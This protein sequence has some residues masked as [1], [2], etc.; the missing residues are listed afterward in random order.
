VIRAVAFAILAALPGSGLGAA[1]GGVRVAEASAVVSGSSGPGLRSG[2]ADAAEAEVKRNV[3]SGLPPRPDSSSAQSEA[4]DETLPHGA[5][6]PAED[7]SATG[8][9][10]SPPAEDLLGELAAAIARATTQGALR[11]AP[12]KPGAEPPEGGGP[13]PSAANIRLRLPGEEAWLPEGETRAGDC[14]PEDAFNVA[15]WGAGDADPAEAI[16]ALRS[17][18]AADI[19]VIDEARALALARLY[20]SLGFG[21]E[22]RAVL[23]SLVPRDPSAQLLS[24]I[25]RVVDGEPGPSALF[26]GLADCP[27]RAQLWFA[28]AT[29]R[30]GAP[31]AVEFAVSELPLA[32]RRQV[33]PRLIESYARA[34]DMATA[35][36][37]RA[38]VERAA[39]P[40]G[41]GFELAAARLDIG[42]DNEAGLDPIRSL[43]APTSPSSDDALALL[44]ETVHDRGET[45]DASTLAQAGTRADD[46]RGTPEGIRLHV[47]LVR[48]LLR[49]DAFDAAAL[50]LGSDGVPPDMQRS[51]ATEFFDALAERG[52]DGHVLVHGAGLRDTHAVHVRNGDV[53]LRVAERLLDLGLPEVARSY[54]P[55]RAEEL[56]QVRLAARLELLSGDPAAALARLDGL[57]AP[58]SEDMALRADALRALGRQD[59]AREIRRLGEPPGTEAA[60]PPEV[61]NPD[62]GVPGGSSPADA[63]VASERVRREIDALLAPAP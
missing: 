29:G 16:T 27:G 58:A 59:Q 5:R 53:G 41:A 35:E 15:A 31:D 30:A 55:E 3:G 25:S 50:R 44:L 34:G 7:Q 57:S 26:A 19:D 33:G 47:G 11:L 52:Q 38:A 23:D 32:L 61:A 45:V 62:A 22:A 43:A 18:L 1:A 24:A 60:T 13:A 63:V 54:L 42:R 9:T 8:P 48:A 20:I 12:A 51:L 21:A 2:A 40:H 28:L 14:P 56:A 4:S 37:I 46:L 36:T 6:A 17:S 10:A 49:A 39:G